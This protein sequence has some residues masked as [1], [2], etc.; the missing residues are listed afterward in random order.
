MTIIGEKQRMKPQLCLQ[1][2]ALLD[3]ASGMFENATP[4]AGDC[5]LCIHCGFAMVFTDE[6]TFRKPTPDEASEIDNNYRVKVGR[7]A[8]S[9][10]RDRRN[11]T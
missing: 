4:K 9:N 3:A 1:C 6:L 10:L 8:I 7:L 2:G 11:R 5:S